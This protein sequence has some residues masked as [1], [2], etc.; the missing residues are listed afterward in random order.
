MKQIEI[1]VQSHQRCETQPRPDALDDRLELALGEWVVGNAQPYLGLGTGHESYSGGLAAWLATG[2]EDPRVAFAEALVDAASGA[3][4]IAVYNA[5]FESMVLQGLRKAVPHL[6]R[7][8]DAIDG[9]LVDLLPIVR[10][11]V[12]HP[13]FQ[14]S[15]S[16]KKTLPALCPNLSYADLESVHDGLTASVEIPRLMFDGGSMDEEERSC[17]R[18]ALLR[19][20][21]LETWAMVKLREALIALSSKPS[22]EDLK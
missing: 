9:K 10:G 16:I 7:E 3:D 4:S 19:Y 5:S 15:F 11:H 1:T 6:E 8:L 20:C 14:G 22:G 21:H 17:L 18:R 13:L 12:Y 2:P